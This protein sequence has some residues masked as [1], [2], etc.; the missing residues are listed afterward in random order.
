MLAAFFD[1]YWTNEAEAQEST[2]PPKPRPTPV[3]IGDAVLPWNGSTMLHAI[4]Q[5]DAARTEA[6]E[7]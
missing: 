1:P 7:D 6:G 3:F 4:L 2:E 5:S